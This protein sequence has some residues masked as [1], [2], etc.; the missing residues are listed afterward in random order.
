[1]RPLYALKLSVFTAWC[2]TRGTDTV[3]CDI[4]LILFFLQ[5][6]LDKRRS[7]SMVKVFVATIAASHIAGQSVGR[8]NLVVSFLKGS[9][10]LNPPRPFTIPSWD[11]PT[12]LKALKGSPFEP[13]Q[14]V[15]LRSLSLKTA[16]LLVL[17]SVKWMGDLQALSVSP[18][19]LHFGPNN[20]KVILKPRHGYVPKMLSTRFRAQVIS[21]SALSPS[22]EDQELKLL[23]PI[24]ALIIY[25]EHSALF[26]LSDQL[27]VCFGNHTKRRPVMKQ[28]LSRWIVDAIT[29]AYLFSGLHCPIGERAHSTRGTFPIVGVV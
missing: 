28:K 2:S 14:S 18:T 9:R 15:D 29:L 22:D 19:C 17:V 1:M 25:L 7:P 27:L 16:L 5:E 21:L 26:R 8:N 24:R 20:S 11:L 6:L 12:V 10:R 4:L 23:C 13:L 3:F